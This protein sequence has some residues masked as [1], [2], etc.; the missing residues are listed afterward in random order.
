MSTFTVLYAVNVPHYG[1]V[2]IEAGTAAEA[3]ATAKT[4]DPAEICNERD[5]S[6]AACAR[7]V[8]ITDDSGQSIAEGVTLDG[9]FL[10]YG[11]RP[12]WLLCEAAPAMLE[13]LQKMVTRSDDLL[14]ALACPDCR[15]EHLVERLCAACH[16]AKA[17]IAAAADEQ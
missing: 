13:S 12:A 8:S 15:N 1:S 11:G 10:R 2:Q 17:V 4:R 7:I 6:N 14:R 5:R 9:A 3:I 16:V